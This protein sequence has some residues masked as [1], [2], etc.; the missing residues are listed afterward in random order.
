[1]QKARLVVLTDGRGNVPLEASRMG[2]VSL[3]INREGIEDTLV[4]GRS[5]A[6]IKG[7]RVSLLDPQPEQH[8]ELPEQLAESMKAEMVPV[9]RLGWVK[10][11][12]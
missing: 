2:K 10:E 12:A 6:G 7:L 11:E 3:P 9:Q 4:L 5:I 8:A 1:M